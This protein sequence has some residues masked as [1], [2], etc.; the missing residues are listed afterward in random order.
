MIRLILN[1]PEPGDADE[2]ARYA[3]AAQFL[4]NWVR[5]GLL[6][7]DPDPA[8]YV[9]HQEFE[10]G[11]Q[12]RIRRGFMARVRL[13]R[14]GEGNIY[15]H[16]ETHAAAKADRLKLTMACRANLSQIFGLYPDP[17]NEAQ[18]LLEN[19]I[20]RLHT[21]GGHR[22]SGRRASPVAGD[23]REDDCRGGRRA[24]PSADLRRRWPSSL[25]NRLQLPRPRGQQPP[26]GSG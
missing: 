26:A 13:Q 3:R 7:L 23:R 14:F 24:G 8:L 22:P 25:R 10:F 5:E 11:G 19:A 16:E 15:P 4:R 2:D 20:R 21:A 6:S 1:R 18:Q 17:D 9:Y 12:Q